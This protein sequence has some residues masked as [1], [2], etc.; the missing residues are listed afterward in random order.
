MPPTLLACSGL[1]AHLDL[2][3]SSPLGYFEKADI[4]KSILTVC[5][6]TVKGLNP[7]ESML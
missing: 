5:V 2:F 3:L 4:Y 7:G 1:P 6:I